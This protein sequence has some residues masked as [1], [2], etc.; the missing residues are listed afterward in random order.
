[1]LRLADLPEYQKLDAVLVRLAPRSSTDE[2]LSAIRDI[3][4]DTANK[5]LDDGCIGALTCILKNTKD[6][7]T[8]V[9]DGKAPRSRVGART[10]NPSV[11]ASTGKRRTRRSTLHAKKVALRAIVTGLAQATA[12]ASRQLYR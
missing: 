11:N 12:A 1:M 2:D 10:A 3:I 7:I 8:A 4:V 9:A 6:A 5:T